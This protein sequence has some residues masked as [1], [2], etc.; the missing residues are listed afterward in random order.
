M[1][2]GLLV[3]LALGAAL[4]TW[5]A[6]AL[7]T[8]LV[9]A[10]V[11]RGLTEVQAGWLLFAGSA[12]SISGRIAVGHFTDRI[13]GRGFGAIAVLTGAGVATFLLLAT[14]PGGLFAVLV[15]VAFAT[16][17][18][19]P[20]LMTYT[21]VNANAASAATSSGITQAG[22]FFGAGVGPIVLG[23]VADRLG[24]TAIWLIVAGTLAIA[25]LTVA[26]VGRLATR[27]SHR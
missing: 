21:V 18:G 19:W 14:A 8:Y 17:W 27:V 13:G 9:A 24:F 15:L 7:S 26:A 11:D 5:G 6:I 25:S 23:L 12:A 16:G 22:I 20:G 1:G 2:T 4:A 10:A 3:G